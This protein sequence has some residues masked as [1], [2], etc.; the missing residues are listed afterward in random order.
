MTFVVDTV[1]QV[2]NPA[3][4]TFAGVILAVPIGTSPETARQMVQDAAR[5]WCERVT[6]TPATLCAAQARE[7]E[8]RTAKG[9]V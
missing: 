4:D 7:D 6:I 3:G 5:M 2:T 1:G 9:M 8:A